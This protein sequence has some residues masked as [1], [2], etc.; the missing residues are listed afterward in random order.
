MYIVQYHNDHNSLA[1]AMYGPFATAQEATEFMQYLIDLQEDELFKDRTAKLRGTNP[2][3]VGYAGY[4]AEELLAAD[5][6][7]DLD[8]EV[9]VQ[10]HLVFPP[11]RPS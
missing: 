6:N 1:D 9:W 2:N 3:E 8:S 4:D 10:I 7:E 5:R 11:N